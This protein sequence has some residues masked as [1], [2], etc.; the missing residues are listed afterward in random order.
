MKILLVLKGVLVGIMISSVI[1]LMI[2]REQRLWVSDLFN[3]I[4]DRD[5]KIK[6]QQGDIKKCD[7]VFKN[8]GLYKFYEDKITVEK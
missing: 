2:I 4:K 5:L 1:Y 3:N 6:L 8:L 7:R